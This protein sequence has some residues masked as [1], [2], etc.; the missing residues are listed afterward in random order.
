MGSAGSLTASRWING[1]YQKE[2][3]PPSPPASPPYTH[4]SLNTPSTLMR[5][6]TAKWSHCNRREGC[7]SATYFHSNKHP[8]LFTSRRIFMSCYD[9]GMESDYF[10]KQHYLYVGFEVFTAV[11]MKNVAFW[12]IKTEFVPHKRH[13]T[14]P[15]QRPAD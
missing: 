15:L 2:G 3:G 4:I 1:L 7:G 5:S 11:T 10:P 13:I 12:D 6:Q 8:T 14:S 9:L